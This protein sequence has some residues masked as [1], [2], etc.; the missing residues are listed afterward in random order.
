MT[1]KVALVIAGLALVAAQ[2]VQAALVLDFET[3]ATGLD[4][5]STPLITPYGTITASASGGSGLNVFSDPG[6]TGH[7]G[8][9][10]WHSSPADEYGQLAFGF[11]VSSI[12]FYWSGRIGGVFT[13]QAL[14]SSLN[15]VASFFDSNT[16]NDLPGGPTTLSGLDIRYLRFGDYPGGLSQVTLDDIQIEPVPEPGTMLLLGSGLLGLAARRRR[17]S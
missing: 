15:V 10:L 9:F 2:P 1:S 17:R 7:S 12:T 3:S 4:I 8:N 16:D 11:G 6:N 14:D 13:A 5:V